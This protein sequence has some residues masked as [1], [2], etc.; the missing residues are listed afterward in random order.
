MRGTRS[1]G[2]YLLARF[3]KTP[4][5]HARHNERRVI[6]IAET[7]R[8]T[9]SKKLREFH[10]TAFEGKDQ[11]PAGRTYRRAF[12]DQGGSLHVAVSPM[13]DFKGTKRAA[14][15]RYVESK[16]LWEYARRWGNLPR[17]NQ[18]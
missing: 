5:G 1:P 11:H 18:T 7:S 17:C 15:L 9:I 6:Y 13:R 16:L 14:Y 3:R 8:S 2:L 4:Q 10:H 12:R